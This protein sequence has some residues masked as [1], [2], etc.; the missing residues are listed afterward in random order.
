M[1]MFTGRKVTPY[2]PIFARLPAFSYLCPGALPQ[3]P[4]KFEIFMTNINAVAHPNVLAAEGANEFY[5]TADTRGTL[6]TPDIIR[7]L[8]A[9]GIATLN[10]NGEAFVTLFL[11]ECARAVAEGYNVVT[12]FFRASLSLRGKVFA[13]DLGHTLDPERLTVGVNLRA[14]KAAREAV[15]GLRV[16]PYQQ[17]GLSGP[18]IQSVVDPTVGEEGKLTPGC[19]VL[20]KGLR[21]AVKGEDSSVGVYFTSLEDEGVEVH[22]PASK[23]FPNKPKRLQFMLPQEVGKGEWKVRVVTQ[24]GANRIHTMKLIVE[25]GYDWEVEV[26]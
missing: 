5:L 13:N 20:L 26:L 11:E 18:V 8:E 24:S 6:T 9:R 2:F 21:M 16:T 19:M 1:F 14:G 3:L 12:P 23:I 22:I 4:F 7:R 15:S 10:V 17:P 25:G